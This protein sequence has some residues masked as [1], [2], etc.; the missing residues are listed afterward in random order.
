MPYRTEADRPD[1]VYGDPF[2]FFTRNEL[3]G[4]SADERELIRTVIRLD[5]AGWHTSAWILARCGE[6]LY[7]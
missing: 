3:R 5:L 2:P 4:M 6:M 7:G 1:C